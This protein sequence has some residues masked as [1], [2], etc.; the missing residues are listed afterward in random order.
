[1]IK[2]SLKN[3]L[4]FILLLLAT[5]ANA[6]DLAVFVKGQR[7]YFNITD[8]EKKN[9]EVTYKG[10]I[11]D[12]NIP[13]V[14]GHLE[15]PS[16]IT[17]GNVVYNVTS[18]GQKAFA[19]AD[20]LQSVIIPTGIEKVGDF[21]FEGCIN[22]KNIVFPTNIVNFGQGVF[23][24]C[25]KIENVTLGSDWKDV[26]LTMFRWSDKMEYLDIPAKIE[27]IKGLKSIKS[28]RQVKVDPNNRKFSSDNGMLYDKS[29]SVLYACPRA[30]SGK[31]K[32]VE[33]TKKILEG[34]LTDCVE[35]TFIDFPSSLESVS[36]RETMRMKK[37]NTV[38]MRA[39]T[40]IV[41][42][43]AGGKGY[44]LF[45]TK[46]PKLRILLPVSNKNEYLKMIP[47]HGGEYSSNKEGVPFVVEEYEM[48]SK[49]NI[50]FVKSF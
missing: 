30:Y 5:S 38:V 25:K 36:F 16:K 27:I 44:F 41:T 9:V 31:V 32:V 20:G 34:A 3:L 35:I 49:K 7:L 47:E 33:G 14:K 22:L 17:E 46:V 11:V 21:A 19:N 50:K 4:V 10:S 1:M 6:H 45:Q 28:L 29:F 12:N 48:T 39:K 40:P 37:L 43:Y 26:N 24:R 13:E 18:I 23:F 8:K 2:N 42:A 15:I